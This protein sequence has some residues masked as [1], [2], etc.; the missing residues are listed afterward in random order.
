MSARPPDNELQLLAQ[1][2]GADWTEGSYYDDAEAAMEDQWSEIIWPF[3]C[4]CDFTCVLE[5]AGGHGR[6]TEKLRALARKLYVVDIL[7]ENVEFLRIRFRDAANVVVL[8]NNGVDLGAIPDGE[9]TLVYSW[10]SMVHF[11]SDVVRAY[12]REFRRVLRE[13]GQGFCHYS[14]VDADPTG[15]Y[16]DHPGWRNFMSR[17]LFEHYAWKEGLEPVRTEVIRQDPSTGSSDA[18]TLFRTR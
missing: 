5:L 4:H 18:V 8:L 11:D 2:V 9:A 6:N 3:I 1:Q 17:G 15:S 10:D 12:L 16:R 13:G 7:E 14:N